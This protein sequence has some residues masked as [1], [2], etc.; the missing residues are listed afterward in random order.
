[1]SYTS[2]VQPSRPEIGTSRRGNETLWNPQL[3]R[4]SSSHLTKLGDQTGY[5]VRLYPVDVGEGIITLPSSRITIGRDAECGVVLDDPD[6]SRKHASIEIEGGRYVVRD[7]GS[8]NGTAVNDRRVKEQ[9]LTS[10]DRVR[11][12]KTIF[13][14]LRGY[15][16]E[17]QYYE[18]IYSMMITDALTG[19]PN[20]R[21]FQEA[22]DREFARS[23]RHHRP[24][25]LG[26][27]DLD[28]FKKVNDT[29]GHL[30]GDV[31]LREVCTRVRKVIRKDEVFARWGG[32]EFVMLLPE[33][34]LAQATQFAER[35]RQIIAAEPVRLETLSIP[36]TVS[37]GLAHTNGSTPATPELLV[38]QADAKLYDAKKSGRNRVQS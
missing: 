34:T 20:K 30:G 7:L 2:P 28:H 35:I 9:P 8:T 18:T 22:L 21:F 31:V 6:V 4:L 25:S 32:E 16:V 15:D 23:R 29:Y 3:T 26:V 24:L 19:V 1:V 11:V 13:K 10:G 33:S 37:I 27:L 14:F 38:A 12:G 5:L 36:V 17:K